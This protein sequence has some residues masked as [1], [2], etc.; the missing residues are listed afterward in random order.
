MTRLSKKGKTGITV[1]AGSPEMSTGYG[2]D[3][4]VA[5]WQ[6]RYLFLELHR[7]FLQLFPLLPFGH[8]PPTTFSRPDSGTKPLEYHRRKPVEQV[9]IN[10]YLFI[11][12]L[13]LILAFSR[14]RYWSL[15]RPSWTKVIWKTDPIG[16]WGCKTDFAHFFITRKVHKYEITKPVDRGHPVDQTWRYRDGYSEVGCAGVV[17]CVGARIASDSILAFTAATT[18]LSGQFAALSPSLLLLPRLRCR[19]DLGYTLSVVVLTATIAHG[20]KKSANTSTPT[21]ALML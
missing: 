15:R 3:D 19:H 5:H 4:K 9:T 16:S 1:V 6:M 20:S 10:Y 2:N 21:K 14:Y 7:P 18:V 8:P 11:T 12:I 13:A 17:A